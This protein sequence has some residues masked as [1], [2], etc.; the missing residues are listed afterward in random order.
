MDSPGNHS[1]RKEFSTRALT[2]TSEIES[3][4]TRDG[5]KY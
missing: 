1:L 5:G 3:V 2:S 4:S